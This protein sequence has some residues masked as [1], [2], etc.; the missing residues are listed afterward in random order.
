M[1]ELKSQHER[2]IYEITN[3]NFQKIDKLQQKLDA[4]KKQSIAKL[5][6]EIQLK[7]ERIKELEK[8]EKK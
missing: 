2:Q 8:N 7:N 5:K 1:N 3:E 6:E 4:E